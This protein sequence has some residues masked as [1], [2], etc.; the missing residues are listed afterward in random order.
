M[1]FYQKKPWGSRDT[2]TTRAQFY[3]QNTSFG[4]F[5]QR[6]ADKF[7]SLPM[8]APACS[9]RAV[10]PT[11]FNSTVPGQART[12][13]AQGGL[14]L[15]ARWNG[16]ELH[17]G[18]F[19]WSAWLPAAVRLCSVFVSTTARCHFLATEDSKIIWYQVDNHVAAKLD[20]ETYRHRANRLR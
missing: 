20:L 4:K 3:P 16:A 18:G 10:N 5:L 12:T 13:C 1:Q 19:G 6:N 2:R 14:G 15:A 17:G 11:D 9:Y 8:P 7:R